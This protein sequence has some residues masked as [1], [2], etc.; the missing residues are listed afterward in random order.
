VLVIDDDEAVRELEQ[1]FL[2]RAG[3]VV[4]LAAGGKE[5]L[6]RLDN[7]PAPDCVVLD[8]A[9]PDVDGHQVLVSLRR[10][11][12]EVP[13]VVVT[14]FVGTGAERPFGEHEVYAAL[15]KPCEPDLLIDTVIRA[16]AGRG[17]DGGAS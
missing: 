14:G 7:Q 3:F 15:E 11:W 6:E 9:M 12:P 13:V 5:A 1:L 4:E 8:L 17:P 16:I 10:S 2:E